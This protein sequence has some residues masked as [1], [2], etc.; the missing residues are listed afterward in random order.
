LDSTDG[1]T[2]TSEVGM[3]LTVDATTVCANSIS[4]EKIS[5]SRIGA[6]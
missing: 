2:E 4:S 5:R 6:T 1:A 3:K